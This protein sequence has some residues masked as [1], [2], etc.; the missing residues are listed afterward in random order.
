[1]SDT[2]KSPFHG[3]ETACS[4]AEQWCVQEKVIAGL[5][6]DTRVDDIGGSAV[7]TIAKLQIALMRTN[8][9]FLTIMT[10]DLEI[11]STQQR[12]SLL[13]K[14]LHQKIPLSADVLRV[15]STTSETVTA[16]QR[17]RHLLAV[18]PPELEHD[19]G[20]S[21][22]QQQIPGW[23]ANRKLV[24]K[25]LIAATDLDSQKQLLFTVLN[26]IREAKSSDGISHTMQGWMELADLCVAPSIEAHMR[27]TTPEDL[28]AA[29]DEERKIAEE[30]EILA[31]QAEI[32]I[33]QMPI[34]RLSQ[35]AYIRAVRLLCSGS[36]GSYTHAIQETRRLDDDALWQ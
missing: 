33:R 17:I 8:R 11:D 16:A 5:A 14:I 6:G 30:Y 3:I 9:K 2:K 20:I 35:E 18:N 25:S 24:L 29:V 21:E 22:H 26:D 12:L 1:M 4:N 7:L 19:V 31:L 27:A 10:K 34:R 23:R 36:Q 15:V 28:A 13:R 32:D